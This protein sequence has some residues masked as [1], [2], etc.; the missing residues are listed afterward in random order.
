[1]LIA[2][3]PKTFILYF[4]STHKYKSAIKKEKTESDSNIFDIGA[5]PAFCDRIISAARWLKRPVHKKAEEKIPGS[6]FCQN[7]I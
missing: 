6:F 2:K 4:N 3:G 1:M 7:N 5:Y